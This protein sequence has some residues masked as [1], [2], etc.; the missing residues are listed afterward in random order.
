M[1]D[2][3]GR[4]VTPRIAPRRRSGPA[5]GS[6]GPGGDDRDQGPGDRPAVPGVAGDA[7]DPDPSA[8]RDLD[9]RAPC[10]APGPGGPP[11]P[12]GRASRAGG[13]P[14][15]STTRRRSRRPRTGPTPSVVASA[16]PASRASRPPTEDVTRT[17]SP[18][19]ADGSSATT[20][21]VT[22]P[23]GI[24]VIALGPDVRLAV[25]APGSRGAGSR[26]RRPRPGPRP[27][28][29][30]G[31]P[32][33]W[34]GPRSSVVAEARSAR[35]AGTP[36]SSRERRRG[37]I[38][39]RATGRPVGPGDHELRPR[40]RAQG[41]ADR[42]ARQR[43]ASERGRGRHRSR[44][45]RPEGRAVAQADVGRRVPGRTG[46]RRPPSSGP[47]VPA[48]SSS[49]SPPAAITSA[50]GAGRPSGP[51]TTPD[52]RPGPASSEPAPTVAIERRRTNAVATIS[53]LPDSPPADHRSTIVDGN[54]PSGP[55][56]RCRGW[57]RPGTRG[58]RQ[59]PRKRPS[60]D[61]RGRIKAS[62]RLGRNYAR[63]GPVDG[64]NHR[65]SKEYRRRNRAGR[66]KYAG[67]SKAEARSGGLRRLRADDFMRG[68]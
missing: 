20:R 9:R 28:P 27:A 26:S 31:T 50:P 10:P 43:R 3:A 45:V 4:D 29:R 66:A 17:A 65:E 52:T 2:Q 57:G 42:Q 13:G 11:G 22:R 8:E 67:N 7:G 39:T 24:R 35:A 41:Q 40:R 56:N 15:P 46:P 16:S 5:R 12:A 1:R 58:V 49:Q 18:A 14:G 68:R 37:T 48:A 38:R 34:P 51:T 54:P 21:P 32:R 30:D 63:F 61:A 6:A 25:A 55:A 36:R 47:G 19:T 64:K 44:P 53:G 33:S 23:V 59:V 60:L 62:L